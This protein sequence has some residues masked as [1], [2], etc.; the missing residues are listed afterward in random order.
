MA[1]KGRS[2]EQLRPSVVKATVG[3]Q[4]RALGQ[5][6]GAVPGFRLP[7]TSGLGSRSHQHF[8]VSLHKLFKDAKHLLP[9][10]RSLEVGAAG[11]VRFLEVGQECQGPQARQWGRGQPRAVIP[12]SC[13]GL[14]GGGRGWRGRQGGSGGGGRQQI[15]KDRA[16][17]GWGGA[18][19]SAPAPP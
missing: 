13:R 4:L 7:N 5:M 2:V 3:T 17:W 11:T 6:T 14:R 16:Q 12:P 10:S 1:Q 19:R 9:A 15:G 18:S 8:L